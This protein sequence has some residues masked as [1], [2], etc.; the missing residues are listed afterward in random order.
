MW[1]LL[2]VTPIFFSVI[3]FQTSDVASLVF[4]VVI[5]PSTTILLDECGTWKTYITTADSP[6]EAGGYSGDERSVVV[7]SDMNRWHYEPC[8]LCRRQL[9][10]SDDSDCK[11]CNVITAQTPGCWPN[12]RR[13]NLEKRCTSNWSPKPLTFASGLLGKKKII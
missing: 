7:T 12:D 2:D 11:I 6:W 1:I 9:I 10:L 5:N 13:H 4:L 3:V 8:G